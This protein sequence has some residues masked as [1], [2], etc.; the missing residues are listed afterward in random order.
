MPRGGQT[1]SAEGF[2]GRDSKEVNVRSAGWISAHLNVTPPEILCHRPRPTMVTEIA[3]DPVLAV[4]KGHLQISFQ[5]A[6]ND[7]FA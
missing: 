5:S 7:T 1:V 2:R 3:N 4:W 6:L